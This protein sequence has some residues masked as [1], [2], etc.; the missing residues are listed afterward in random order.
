MSPTPDAPPPALSDRT[1]ARARR[2]MKGE[3]LEGRPDPAGLQSLAEIV[4]PGED[5]SDPRFLRWLYEENPVRPAYELMTRSGGTVSGHIAGVPIR[6]RLAGKDV[7]GGIAV[8]AITH[9]D[10]RGKGIFII[11]HSELSRFT[12]TKDMLFLFGFANPN[13]EKGC[14]RHL[15][16]R[17]LG[18]FPLWILPLDLGK[19]MKAQE[20]TPGILRTV[21]AAAGAPLLGL[22]KAARRP[23]GIGGLEVERIESFGPEFDEFWAS[24]AKDYVNV[25]VR[26]AKFLD[27]RFVRPPTR[28]YDIFAAR[29]DGRLTGYLVGTLSHFSGLTWAMIVDLLV[30]AS[31]AGRTAASRLIAAYTRHASASGADIAASLMLRHAPAAPAFRKNGYLIAPRRLMPREFPILLQWNAPQAPPPGV[32]D[33]RS[34]YLTMGDYDAV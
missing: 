26:D 9:P 14:L 28:R 12:A 18:R 15:N 33:P 34:W 1:L 27:W 5:L 4:F 22:W 23:R 20:G 10:H 2:M 13:S 7:L 21:G 8:N 3:I 29:S 30:P 19:V 17:D 6:Y 24:T 16:Y 31:P 25:A 32:F 11:L